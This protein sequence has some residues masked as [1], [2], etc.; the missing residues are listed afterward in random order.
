M[1][2]LDAV[3]VQDLGAVGLI[4]SMGPGYRASFEY[5]DEHP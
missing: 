2:V 5:H 4:N 3:I 1:L